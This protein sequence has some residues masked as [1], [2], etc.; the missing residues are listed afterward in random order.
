MAMHQRTVVKGKR[1]FNRPRYSKVEIGRHASPKMAT[2]YNPNA[3]W[4]NCDYLLWTWKDYV[5]RLLIVAGIMCLP[6]ALLWIMTKG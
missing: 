5:C 1:R 3:E 4:E 2:S 6:L